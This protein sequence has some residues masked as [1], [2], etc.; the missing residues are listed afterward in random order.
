MEKVPLATTKLRSGQEQISQEIASSDRRRITSSRARLDAHFSLFSCLTYSSQLCFLAWHHNNH[1]LLLHCDHSSAFL[2]LRP[3][4]LFLYTFSGASFQCQCQCKDEES[5]QFCVQERQR[6]QQY[7]EYFRRWIR[8]LSF[9]LPARSD[10]KIHTHMCFSSAIQP[11]ELQ[12]SCACRMQS[13]AASRMHCLYKLL[14]LA[15]L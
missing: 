11:S 14:Y 7:E 8:F 3:T 5:V 10:Q 6:C 9:Q 15:G 12:L 13:D 4:T 2:T 1:H